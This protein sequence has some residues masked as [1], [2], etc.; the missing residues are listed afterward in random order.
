MVDDDKI[1]A[2]KLIF[3]FNLFLIKIFSK[4]NSCDGYTGSIYTISI[5]SAS[6]HQQSPWY[7][8]RCPSTM[9][10]TYS[11]GAYSDQKV[12]CR[13]IIKKNKFVSIILFLDN[14]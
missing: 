11:S 5:S 12:V 13:L 4:I 6:E 9:A 8:E 10:T 7:A 14:N 2:S 1:I 3:S